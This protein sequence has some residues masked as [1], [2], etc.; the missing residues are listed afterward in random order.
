MLGLIS[1]KMMHSLVRLPIYIT[2]LCACLNISIWSPR[3]QFLE[4]VQELVS[5]Q[6]YTLK[7]CVTS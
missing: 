2:V 5:L 6:A 1:L 7:I 4:L 3:E